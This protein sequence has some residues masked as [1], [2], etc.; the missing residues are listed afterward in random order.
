M[1]CCNFNWDPPNEIRRWF[2]HQH[3]GVVSFLNK[4]CI[5]STERFCVHKFPNADKRLSTIR[6]VV[7]A[8]PVSGTRHSQR[9]C[10]AV[11]NV[12][13]VLRR[14]SPG[15]LLLE[16]TLR[17]NLSL[18]QCTSR[19]CKRGVNV[20]DITKIIPAVKQVHKIKQQVYLPIY[21]KMQID[22]DTV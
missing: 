12:S 3:T 15:I 4:C 18:H 5:S 19:C 6:S 9:I 10:R 1:I 7:I 13:S 16:S 20:K 11:Q 17:W 2:G 8:M 22:L 21:N 14:V